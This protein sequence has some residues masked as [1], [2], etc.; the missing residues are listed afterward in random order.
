[1]Q[2]NSYPGAAGTVPPADQIQR[3]PEYWERRELR[4]TSNGLGFF[5]LVY[6]GVMINIASVLTIMLQFSHSVTADNYATV[7]FFYQMIPAVT[8]PLI[9]GFFYRLISRRRISDF[10][11]KSHVPA[12]TLV[13]LTCLGMGAAMIANYLAGIFDTNISVFELK[14]TVSQT[15]DTSDSVSYIMYALSTAAVPALAEELAFRGIFM[16]IMRKYGDA[17]A[18]LTS[19]IMFGAM[20]GNTTQ[21]VF[22]FVL[23]LI[24]AYVDCKANSIVPSIII[25]FANNF[26]AVFSDII[27]SHNIFDNNTT[28]AIRLGM[29]V[30]FCLLAVLSYIYLA[31]SDKGFFRVSDAD[32]TPFYQGSL[33]S[34]KD[35][36]KTFFKSAG[37]IISLCLFAAETISFLLPEDLF[38]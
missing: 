9:A 27:Q 33:L 13:L 35:K 2:Y 1:M 32:H 30:M 16:S 28:V 19:A 31:R 18:I 38:K 10:L 15:S 3:T 8:A 25:H 14:N 4:K 26:Y 23:G 22:A 36:M 5:V 6:F 11:P 34:L 7:M 20:H 24:F 17:F 29:V 37:V 21:I 12:K